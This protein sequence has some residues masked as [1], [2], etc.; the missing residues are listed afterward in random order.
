MRL[1]LETLIAGALGAIVGWT[2][3]ALVVCFLRHV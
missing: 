1:T 2:I 3:A